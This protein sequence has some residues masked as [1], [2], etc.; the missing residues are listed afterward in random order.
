MCRLGVNKETHINGICVVVTFCACLTPLFSTQ[1]KLLE[2]V[3]TVVIIRFYIQTFYILLTACF[4]QISG[5]TA[6]LPCI[7]STDRV[8]KPRYCLL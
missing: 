2:F 7:T 6:T 4:V 1:L 3:V 5:Q 8:L